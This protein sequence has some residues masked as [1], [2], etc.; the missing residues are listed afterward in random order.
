MSAEQ[1]ARRSCRTSR[2]TRTKTVPTPFPRQRGACSYADQTVVVG[3]VSTHRYH[4]SGV[5]ADDT[6][7]SK[8]LPGGPAAVTASAKRDCEDRCLRLIVLAYPRK[9]H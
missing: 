5:S 3:A 6:P 8:T 9:D 2:P 1:P 7:K 4:I